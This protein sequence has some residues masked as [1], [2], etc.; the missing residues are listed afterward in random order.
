MDN[1]DFNQDPI[2]YEVTSD[3]TVLKDMNKRVSTGAKVFV[4]LV[5]VVG[6]G[7]AAFHFKQE[8]EK[9]AIEGEL[10]AINALEDPSQVP[11]RLRALLADASDPYVR[12][13]II[14]NLGYVKDEQAVPMLVQALDEKG[15]VRRAAA[16]ALAAIGSPA[17]D[18]AKGKLLAILPDTDEVDRSPVVWALAVLGEGQASEAILEQF[19]AGNLQ[20]KEGFDPSVI[21]RAV[22]I[23]RLSSDE[24]LK[25]D[26][27]SVRVLTAHALAEAAT[28][29][30]VQPLSRLIEYELAR[31]EDAQSEEVI[32]AAAA[33]LGRTG[34]PGAADALFALLESK[35]AMRPNVFDALKKSTPAPGLIALL[36]QAK[37]D[38][39]RGDLI[40]LLADTRDPRAADPLAGVLKSDNPALRYQAAIALAELGDDR[41]VDALLEFATGEDR[42]KAEEALVA[43][44]IV[45]RP[46]IADT[47][48]AVVEAHPIR[49]SAILRAVGASGDQNASGFLEKALEGDDMG[50][51]ALALADLNSDSGFKKLVAKLPR[52]KK[53]DM[54]EPSVENE[55]IMLD[56]K[57]AIEGVGRYGRPEV[58]PALMT[59]IED[60]L[61][62]PRL[63]SLAAMS[64]GAVGTDN[65]IAKAIARVE[66]ADT[67]EATKRYY[68]QALWQKPRTG[69]DAPLLDLVATNSEAE[70]RRT[71]AIALGYAAN[72]ANDARLVELLEN[73]IGGREAAIAIA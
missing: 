60:P 54:S 46:G 10:Q 31:P 23:A 16:R 34:D 57:A 3:D 56:R 19:A 7:L 8:G 9:E 70:V 42:D 41:A 15:P 45:N 36:G 25:N 53:T 38:T 59:I 55:T 62:D 24:L 61:D 11:V 20:D 40:R 22:G 37:D 35:P 39:I 28:P 65:D 68:M 73:P 6:A 72:P 32:R 44:R 27:E 52:P 21:V 12:A 29:E 49:H 50:A 58:V 30:A 4:A 13:R 51:A 5:I 14:L 17:A 18:P 43:L 33:G 1:N 64:L 66:S 71:A 48:M 47:L 26:E 67:D 2:D 63:R 69:L